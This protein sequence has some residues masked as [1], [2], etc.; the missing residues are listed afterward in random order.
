MSVQNLTPRTRS[1][2]AA[3]IRPGHVIVESDAHPAV[4]DR[5]ASRGA[6][7]FWCRYVWQSAAEPLWPLG[8]FHPDSRIDLSV[9]R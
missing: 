5:V 7:T 4:V 8:P 3:D 9:E 6:C 1:V 2:R